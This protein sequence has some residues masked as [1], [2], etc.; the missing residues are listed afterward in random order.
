M[1]DTLSFSRNG[2]R[3]YFAPRSRYPRSLPKS[4]TV[5]ERQ[6]CARPASLPESVEAC[7]TTPADIR[8]STF[9]DWFFC[10]HSYRLPLHHWQGRLTLTRQA[11]LIRGTHKRT[12]AAVEYRVAPHELEQVYHGYDDVF[13]R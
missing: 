12:G 6:A 2:A 3:L 10:A 9:T 1:R 11:L 13:T 7:W 8:S 5:Q 4:R